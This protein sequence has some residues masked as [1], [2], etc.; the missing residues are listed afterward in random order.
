MVEELSE[1]PE[2]TLGF[3]VWGRITRQDYETIMPRMQEAV[4]GGGEIRVLCQLGPDWEGMTGGA[5]WEDVKSSVEYEVFKRAKWRRIGV[6][7]DLEWVRK[8]INLLGWIAPGE[9]KLFT[10]DQ[11]QQAK[12]WVAE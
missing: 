10:P 11:L 7:T 6:V 2:G 12:A 4:E 9:L 5:I 1:M 3:G 8:M